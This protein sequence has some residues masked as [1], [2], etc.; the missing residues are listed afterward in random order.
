MFKNLIILSGIMVLITS[1]S[2][3]RQQTRD[4]STVIDQSSSDIIFDSAKKIDQ[5]AAEIFD[6]GSV[7]VNNSIQKTFNIS[8]TTGANLTLN[9]TDLKAKILE[10]TRFSSNLDT[11]STCG[12]I[13]KVNKSCSFILTLNGNSND[14]FDAIS[15]NIIDSLS[16]G[17]NPEFGSMIFS[18][19]KLNDVSSTVPL[20]SILRID[21]LSDNF[22]L[23]QGGNQTKRF[24]IGNI[25]T[26]AIK[27]PTII[28][29]VNGIISNNSC[30]VLSSL[31]INGTCFF[32]VKFE[33]NSDPLKSN[34]TDKIQFVSNDLTINS[35]GLEINLAITN[36]PS[37][38]PVISASFSQVGSISNISALSGK[39]RLYIG[40][41]G[42]SSFNSSLINIPNPY[43]VIYNSCIGLIKPGKVCFVDLGLNQLLITN[44]IGVSSQIGLNG[45]SFNIKAG[46]PVISGSLLCKPNFIEVNS[47]CVLAN[48]TRLCQ[49][50]PINSI[51]GT[52]STINGGVLWGSCSSFSCESGFINKDG[53]CIAEMTPGV[54]M[55]TDVYS[56]TGST[57][58]ECGF[59][60]SSGSARIRVANSPLFE[61]S[62][63]ITSNTTTNGGCRF[64]GIQT[65][66]SR[67]LSQSTEGSLTVCRGSGYAFAMQSEIAGINS[68][69][70]LYIMYQASI[71]ARTVRSITTALTSTGL[72]FS[73]MIGLG[74][75]LYYLTS[76]STGSIVTALDVISVPATD[77]NYINQSL[78]QL[79][80]TNTN[81][82]FEVNNNLIMRKSNSF[83]R[84]D[85]LSGMETPIS[86]D[87]SVI[88][89][90]GF[91]ITK[92]NSAVFIELYSGNTGYIYKT[93]DGVNYVQVY[94]GDFYSIHLD[95]QVY[96]KNNHLIAL[97]QGNLVDV[98]E[99]T[100]T[101]T[102]YSEQVSILVQSDSGKIY[103]MESVS[104]FRVFALNDSLTFDSISFGQEA[105]FVYLAKDQVLISV[106]DSNL[107]PSDYSLYS[108]NTL[109]NL[110]TP[111]K[112][113]YISSAGCNI[114]YAEAS[115]VNTLSGTLVFTC[116][117]NIGLKYAIKGVKED[118][119]IIDIVSNNYMLNGVSTYASAMFEGYE[120]LTSAI[121]KI[122]TNEVLAYKDVMLFRYARESSGVYKRKLGIID[123]NDNLIETTFNG[124]ETQDTV[125]VQYFYQY[126][127]AVYFNG[128][129]DF[130]LNTP[131]GSFEIMR[132]FR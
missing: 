127:G 58:T 6:L 61:S 76:N 101:M 34:F 22:V 51:G 55:M 95:G 31:K 78:N 19:V 100:S 30:L 24:Y 107:A 60:I 81:S 83:Y 10:T 47:A 16:R 42:T 9:F 40:N 121:S 36:Q 79:T 89:C 14:S 12:T 41:T 82:F 122:P 112:M 130:S 99:Q 94:T 53:A 62:Q 117:S 32:E 123:S 74:D 48:Q 90:S 92:I 98:N 66:L 84:Y 108:L 49:A 50:R 131:N 13:L 111:R 21:R 43:S 4:I 109:T 88:G 118:G 45:N 15:T 44:A 29:P 120:R 11:G 28:A 38:M 23:S 128:N 115:F 70:S 8:N 63:K 17:T 129:N 124:L 119:S 73:K 85:T 54:F 71:S 114:A 116:E 25:G 26:N 91:G 59:G 52:E 46:Q 3:S 33:Y 125:G 20:S 1:C 110:I 7:S 126:K 93:I 77:S 65:A 67:P 80:A 87:C 75:N 64:S 113:N 2:N 104:P 102:V 5:N 35:N 132:Y 97:N 27:T 96:E 57:S 68:C 37:I 18:G 103:G 106:P 72:N 86:F 39:T 56:V 69:S 105:K